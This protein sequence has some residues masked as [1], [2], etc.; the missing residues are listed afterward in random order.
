MTNPADSTH[1]LVIAR[2]PR[3]RIR[4]KR[5]EDAGDDYRWRRDPDLQRFNAEPVLEASFETFLVQFELD[6]EFGHDR[7]AMFSIE[8]PDGVHIGNLM[9]YNADRAG[10]AFEFGMSIADEALRGKGLGREVT[11]AFPRGRCISG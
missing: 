1:H 9:Y 7:R 10:G 11:A 5:R 2:T 6:L 3:A 8:T 4:R